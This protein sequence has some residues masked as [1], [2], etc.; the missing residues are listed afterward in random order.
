M[1]TATYIPSEVSFTIFGVPVDGW[2]SIT[3]SRTEPLFTYKKAIDGSVNAY[4]NKY[5][6]YEINFSLAQSSYSNT[7][8]HLVLKLFNKYGLPFVMPILLKD[9]SGGT[10]FFATECFFDV[11]PNTEFSQELTNSEWKIVCHNGSYIKAGNMQDE[12]LADS[13]NAIMQLIEAASVIGI[14]LGSFENSLQAAYNS[15]LQAL[16]GLL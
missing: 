1:K 2:D 13:I 10:N 9:G 5:G 14:D 3:L 15:G 6:T 12:D 16:D 7:W 8:L 4:L 11:E